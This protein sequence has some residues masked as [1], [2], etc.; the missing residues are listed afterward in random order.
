MVL[1]GESYSAV[2]SFQRQTSKDE[3]ASHIKPSQEKCILAQLNTRVNFGYK[4]S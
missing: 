4:F 2:V 3:H 1:S